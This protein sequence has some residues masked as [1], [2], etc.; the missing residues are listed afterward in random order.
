MNKKWMIQYACVL[1]ILV[2]AG[3]VFADTP[4][5]AAPTTE[6]PLLVGFEFGKYDLK[7]NSAAEAQL[8]SIAQELKNYPAA[9]LEIEGFADATGPEKVNEKLSDDR[10]LEVRK[11]FLKHYNLSP[12]RVT[13]LAHGEKAP[14]ATNATSEGRRQN[15]VAIARIYRLEPSTTGPAAHNL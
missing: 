3:T 5:K 7:V 1:A 11:Y 2:S 4:K 12:E 14:L 8:A 9:K 13:V 6:Y 10:A 15:R